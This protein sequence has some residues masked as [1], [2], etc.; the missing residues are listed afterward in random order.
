MAEKT[1]TFWIG[2]ADVH[3]PMDVN[4]VPGLIIGTTMCQDGRLNTANSRFLNCAEPY[5]EEQYRKCWAKCIDGV[6]YW[7]YKEENGTLVE[8]D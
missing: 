2:P 1:E 6:W 4:E 5:T 7:K 3:V 8:K